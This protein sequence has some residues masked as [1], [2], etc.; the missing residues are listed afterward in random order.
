[1]VN[2]SRTSPDPVS[3]E[4]AFRSSLKQ[5][6]NASYLVYDKKDQSLKDSFSSLHT[7]IEAAKQIFGI[8]SAENKKLVENKIID[9]L[10]EGKQW[11]KSP[12]DLRLIE[13]VAKQAG[14]FLGNKQSEDNHAKLYSV[15]HA[16]SVNILIQELK[17]S[18][19]YAELQKKHLE[20]HQDKSKQQ[21]S[22]EAHTDSQEKE[23][24]SETDHSHAGNTFTEE[25][26]VGVLAD[27]STEGTSVAESPMEQNAYSSEVTSEAPAKK[28]ISKPEKAPTVISPKRS[29][30]KRLTALFFGVLLAS[31][32]SAYLMNRYSGSGIDSNHVTLGGGVAQPLMLRELSQ[33][34]APTQSLPD[35]SRESSWTSNTTLLHPLLPPIPVLFTTSQAIIPSLN[36]DAAIYATR[37]FPTYKQAETGNK[38]ATPI[39]LGIVG[40]LSSLGWRYLSKSVLGQEIFKLKLCGCECFRIN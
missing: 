1:M 9:L 7:L 34:G 40:I 23:A 16:L 11:L 38:A 27:K 6:A 19:R 13:A 24:H 17:N 32:G 28:V 37:R 39:L 26:V 36:D 18:P 20:D 33:I 15:V 12:E 22:S 21:N 8:K 31:A 30:A 10:T 25:A 5:I 2:F 4:A 29:F 35:F 14:L 3:N